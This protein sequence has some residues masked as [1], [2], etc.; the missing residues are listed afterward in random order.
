MRQ[1]ARIPDH[2]RAAVSEA[3]E[4]ALYRA[5][6][7][8]MEDSEMKKLLSE[9]KQ[10]ERNVA[11]PAD[12][13]RRLK[14]RRGWV[15]FR[16]NLPRVAQAAAVFIAVLSIGTGIALA[17]SPRARQW[18]AGVLESRVVDPD[19]FF[20]ELRSSM[21]DGAA[22]DGRL[23]VVEDNVNISVYEGIDAGPVTYEWR[24]AGNRRIDAL[25]VDG[26]DA[27]V[28]IHD[29]SGEPIE[30]FDVNRMPQRYALGKV[31]LGED[32]S[33]DVAEVASAPAAAILDPEGKR[34]NSYGIP[35]MIV[36]EGKL[37]FASEYDVE[38]EA[39]GFSFKP[40]NV[41]LFSW[42]TSD[43]AL[44]ELGL[45][46]IP[47]D[48]SP[49][50]FGDG[51]L[52]AFDDGDAEARIFRIDGDAFEEVCRVPYSGA[53]RP[54]SFALRREASPLGRREAS[55]LGRREASPLGR[56]EASPLGR[57][58]AS[59]L[60]RRE[61]SPLGRASDGALVY[62][63]DGSVWM[64]PDMDP[65]RAM[66]VAVC[67]EVNG[68]GLLPDGETYAV[69]D[70]DEVR[71]FDLTVPLGEVDE[72]VVDGDSWND[73]VTRRFI[74]EHPGTAVVRD[75][76][77]AIGEA[78]AGRML[79]GKTSGDVVTLEY[80]DFRKA[81]D[82][83]LIAPLTDAAL[84]AEWEKLPEGLRNF[85]SV[86]GRA[87][88]IPVDFY[89]YPDV[90][91]LK[92]NWE[93]VRGS[94]E[95]YPETWL[96]YARW[97]RD[98]SH[99][100][101]A[102]RY[103]IDFGGYER[104]DLDA[105]GQFEM[106]TLWDMAEAF[107]RCWRALGEGVDFN[108][109]E[110]TECLA[111]LAEVDWRAM[112]YGEGDEGGGD[113]RALCFTNVYDPLFSEDDW[114]AGSCTLKIREDAPKLSRA[115]GCFAFVPAAST[116][117]ATAQAYLRTLVAVNR[118]GDNGSLPAAACYDFATDPEALARAAGPGFTAG[119]IA[120]YRERVGDAVIPLLRDNETMVKVR[121]MA[122]EY[123]EGKID[124]GMLCGALNE[125]YR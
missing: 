103:V 55:P 17:T 5:A 34:L 48:W 39:E 38:S 49:E 93:A 32:G 3:L 87:A 62:V 84:V 57:R 71:L 47:M 116:S 59:P 7:Q 24:N 125:V 15:D 20:G 72:L 21:T 112:R 63:L 75:P 109:P 58:E 1:E 44:S 92:T 11:A 4:A 41:R 77:G 12:L 29:Y 95:D 124:A 83:G 70:G 42:D 106:L 45:S 81:R 52:A 118:T 53:E 96:E 111:L 66:R 40:A 8:R 51:Y 18:A 78:Y 10:E 88:A 80:H 37:L 115:S 67:G 13:R 104:V 94:F 28:V 68:R 113:L 114:S 86:D 120:R 98:F 76:G 64:A 102:E 123:V 65:T 16:R 61:A 90:M 2:D 101:A 121:D 9:L 122:V 46:G 97:L 82:A 117:K 27:W 85:L 35:G 30:A 110:F 91:F 14:R 36:Q 100:E 22:V 89:A 119:S 54:G 108:R 56:R 33:F 31:A 73:A 43:G 79:S 60:G 50:L 74:D 23:L 26:E 105:P 19:G 69:V 107:E 25:A 99:S 6:F